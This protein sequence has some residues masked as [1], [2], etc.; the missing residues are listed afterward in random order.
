ARAG[1]DKSR[2]EVRFQPKSMD[3]ARSILQA[4]KEEDYK[5]IVIGRTG[6]SKARELFLGSVTNRAIQTA[7]DKAVWVIV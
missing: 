7:A 4:A 5:T 3:I 1:V 2:V 6:T